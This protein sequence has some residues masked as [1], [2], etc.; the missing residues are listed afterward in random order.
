MLS[1]AWKP[2]ALARGTAVLPPRGA[3]GSRR[4]VSWC[5]RG[6][7]P[8]LGWVTARAAGVVT[9]ARRDAGAWLDAGACG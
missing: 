5:L 9:M 8:A 4:Y 1:A 3:E 2:H 7:V 6:S